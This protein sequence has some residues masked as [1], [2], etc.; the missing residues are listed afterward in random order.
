MKK[1]LNFC[2]IVVFV[3]LSAAQAKEAVD[4]V[5]YNHQTK[6]FHH[7]SCEWAIKCTKS[8]DIVSREEALRRLGV[9]CQVC[10]SAGLP[11]PRI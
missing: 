6:K 11:V 8:C 7:P 5:I 3:L 1:K 10:G 2:L 9:P 4:L